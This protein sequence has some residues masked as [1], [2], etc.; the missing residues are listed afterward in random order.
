MNQIIIQLYEKHI[1]L[2]IFKKLIH[3]SKWELLY[4]FEQCMFEE[5]LNISKDKIHKL[6]LDN[7]LDN[8]FAKICLNQLVN[9]KSKFNKLYDTKTL[10]VPIDEVENSI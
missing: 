5:L 4:D 8:Y 3:Y 9:P 6:F 1:P 7:E 2:K 10:K